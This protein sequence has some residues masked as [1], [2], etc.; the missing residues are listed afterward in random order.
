MRTPCRC[1]WSLSVPVLMVLV[2]PASFA[3]GGSGM[4]SF[5]FALPL[6]VAYALLGF[7]QFF[8]KQP[9]RRGR[10]DSA[11]VSFAHAASAGFFWQ[12][13]CSTRC[14]LACGCR[15]GRPVGQSQI[16]LCP[17]GNGGRPPSLGSVCPAVQP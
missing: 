7:T 10:G 4:V 13:I 3:T 16:G 8:Y 15:A 12:K 17:S 1:S 6:Y 14:S 11:F 5:A 2:L 9:G